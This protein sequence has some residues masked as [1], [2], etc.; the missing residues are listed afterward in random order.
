[1]FINNAILIAVRVTHCCLLCFGLA[2]L[3][4]VALAGLY[5]GMFLP[6]ACFSD[7]ILCGLGQYYV[8]I[9]VY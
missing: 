3:F 9:P 4:L 7:M 2:P 1:M 6:H 5:M 8:Y